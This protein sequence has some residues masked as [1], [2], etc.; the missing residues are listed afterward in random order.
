MKV[1][2]V[3][4][5]AAVALAVAAS[6]LLN[7]NQKFAYEAYATSGARVSH[8]GSNLVGPQWSGNAGGAEHKSHGS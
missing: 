7:E 1:F 5:I 8:P 4:V 3:S 6:F 2:L